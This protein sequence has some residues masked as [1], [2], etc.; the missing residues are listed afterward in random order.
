MQDS[1]P[2]KAV[3]I[4]ALL[5]K[6]FWAKHTMV[7]AVQSLKAFKFIP[8]QRAA[9]E[10]VVGAFQRIYGSPAAGEGPYLSLIQ[11]ADAGA[12]R[13]TLDLSK[14]ASLPATQSYPATALGQDLK[15]VSQ[16]IASNLGT[17]VFMV[18]QGGY[19][20]HAQEAAAHPR[21]LKDLGDA[22]AAFYQD[23][24]QQ[25]RV[26]QVMLM[27]ISE[28]GRRPLENASTG[29]DH[30]TAAPLLVIGGSVKGG[31]YGE[32]PSLSDLDD[33]NLRFSTDFRA[34]YATVV[35]HW[36][37]SDAGPVVL[38]KYSTLPFV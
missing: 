24:S 25:G 22:I 27:T 15:L 9:E 13:A 12:Y 3:S 4:G 36:F 7:P 26:G 17:R 21:L 10:Q 11:I 38:G 35:Q 16:I 31:L 8:A 18:T 32:P 33:G 19:D 23:L 14:T 6:A 37:Q 34:V 30:G 1:N 2:L 28:F 29:T 20:D 5:P